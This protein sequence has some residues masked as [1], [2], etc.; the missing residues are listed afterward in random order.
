MFSRCLSNWSVLKGNCYVGVLL[1]ILV[2]CCAGCS[3]LFGAWNN[4]ASLTKSSRA[5][6]IGIPKSLR[7]SSRLRRLLNALQELSCVHAPFSKARKTHCKPGVRPDVEIP[8]KTV[9]HFQQI[10]GTQ[11]VC[12]QPATRNP[13]RQ[14]T[15]MA[16]QPYGIGPS[17]KLECAEIGFC[18]G[19]IPWSSPTLRYGSSLRDHATCA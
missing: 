3:N 11:M 7:S 5:S 19:P 9:K 10:L 15:P 17:P 13:E 6:L 12:P 18:L 16:V 1:H 4:L 14:R 8:K 2:I